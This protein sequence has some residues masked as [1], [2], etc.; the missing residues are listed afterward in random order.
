M[1]VDQA[2]LV[3]VNYDVPVDTV[4]MMVNPILRRTGI[5]RGLEER[6]GLEEKGRLLY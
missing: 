5:F 2:C 4:E 6:G 3:V 1:D